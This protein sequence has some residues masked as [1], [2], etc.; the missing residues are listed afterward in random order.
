MGKFGSLAAA[1]AD[2]HRVEIIY[3]ATD[4]PIRDKDGNLAW[5]EVLPSDGEAGRAFDKEERAAAFRRAR[6][7][8]SGVDEV[9]QLEQN[10]AKCA[11]LTKAWYL[12]DPVSLEKIDVPCT[13]ENAKELY[14]APGMNWLFIQ[15]WVAANDAA[16][17]MKRSAPGSTPTPSTNSETAAS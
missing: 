12:V 8:R 17:F 14:S 9:D 11:A 6:R 16:N 3:P 15:P 2:V 10:I 4:K 7:S 5:I 1:P 13:A